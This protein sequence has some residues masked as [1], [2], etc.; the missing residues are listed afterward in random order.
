MKLLENASDNISRDSFSKKSQVTNIKTKN[1][2]SSPKQKIY[3][4]VSSVTPLKFLLDQKQTIARSAIRAD[5]T[6]ESVR[7]VK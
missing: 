6:R 2:I 5:D 7:R 3:S 1:I 4:K